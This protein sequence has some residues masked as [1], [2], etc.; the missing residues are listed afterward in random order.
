MN[1]KQIWLIV[2]ISIYGVAQQL[3][4]TTGADHPLF[5]ILMVI[6]GGIVFTLLTFLEDKLPKR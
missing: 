3:M 4:A 2:L 1:S 6:C 5:W